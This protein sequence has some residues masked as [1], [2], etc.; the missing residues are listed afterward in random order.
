MAQYIHFD[1]LLAGLLIFSPLPPI[2]YQSGNK[3]DFFKNRE[4]IMS[5]TILAEAP[6]KIAGKIIHTAYEEVQGKNLACL[7][8]L[9]IDWVRRHSL[10]SCPTSPFPQASMLP[11][12]Q[13]PLHVLR[14]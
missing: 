2:H 5:P 13:E 6:F 11:P 12:T 8:T 4:K 10:S 7:P 3:S 1:G 9:V 14:Y